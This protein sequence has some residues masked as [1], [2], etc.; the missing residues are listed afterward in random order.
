M[1]NIISNAE[2]LSRSEMKNIMAGSTGCLLPCAP[3]II[4]CCCS[5]GRATCVED[6]CDCAVFCVGTCDSTGEA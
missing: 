3:G 5:D 2:V 6:A 1:T 4:R